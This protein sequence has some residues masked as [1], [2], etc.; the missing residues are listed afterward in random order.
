VKSR[1]TADY[2]DERE[3]DPGFVL[4]A[5]LFGKSSLLRSPKTLNLQ[6]L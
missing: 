4:G 6:H 3:K 1:L 5:F 2:R